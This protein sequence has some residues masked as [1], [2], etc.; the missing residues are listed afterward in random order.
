MTGEH[1][2]DGDEMNIHAPQSIQTATEL[3]LIA[4]A[5]LRFVSPAKSDIAIITKQDPVLG[6]YV[7]TQDTTNID[8]KD[9]MNILMITTTGINNHIPKHTIATGKSVF[10]EIIPQINMVRPNADGTNTMWIQN[11]ELINGPINKSQIQLIMRRSWIEYGSKETVN[12]VDDLQRLSLQFLMNDGV[13]IGAGDTRIPATARDAIYKIIETKRKEVVGSMTVYENDPYVMATEAFEIH[14]MKNLS[15]IQ[16]EIQDVVMYNIDKTCGMYLT[17]TSGSNGQP[18]NTGQI[19]ACIGQ[20][21]VEQQRIK[22]KF[23]NRTLPT[24]CQHD[25]S[26]FARGF[27]YNSFMSGMNAMEFFF[28]AM[29]GRE[30]LISTAIKTATTGYIQRK[31]VKFEEDFKVEYDG[32][33]R[34][35][36]DKLIQCA[37]GDNGINTENQ[38]SQKI[39]LMRANNQVIRDSYIYSEADIKELLRSK[40]SSKYSVKINE[41]LYGKLVSMRDSMRKIQRTISTKMITFREL[42]MVPIDLQQAIINILGR[43]NRKSGPIV[44]PYYV[45]R[46]V[47]EMYSGQFSRIM[48]YNNEG[49]IK[50]SDEQRIKLVLKFYLY[51]TLAPKR[52]THAYQLT[53]AEFD[54]IVEYF[55]TRMP[56]ARVEGGEMVG[57]MG[58]QSLGEPV[59]QLNLKTFHL[60]GTG[61]TVTSG[62]ARIQELLGVTKNM[63]SPTTEIILIDAY[64]N[65]KMTASKIA[66]HLKYTTLRD[67]IDHVDICY[68]PDPYHENSIMNQDK[69]TSIFGSNQGKSGCQTEIQGLPWVLRMPISKEKMI[70]RNIT[71]LEIKN[72]FCRNWTRRYEDS[73]GPNKEY[74]RVVDKIAQCALT[75]NFDNSPTPIV[76]IRFDANNYNFN[77]MIQFQEMVINKYRIKG[78]AGITE[79]KNVILEKYN[80]FEADGDVVVKEQY[81]IYTD[82]INLQD[83]AQIN[84][85]DLV[86]TMCNDVV[87]VYE[88]YGVEAARAAYIREF[89]MALEDSGATSN[90]QHIE[91]LTDAVTHMG[92]LIA[93]N[94][95]GANKLDTDPF[96]RASFEKTVEQMLGA[97]IFSES[98]HIRSVSS[99]IMVGSLINGGTGSFDV[100]L[101]HE[102]VQRTMPAKQMEAKVIA[103]KHTAIGDLIAKKKARNS[104]V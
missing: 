92:G 7:M 51:D 32:S 64:K 87:T 47:K 9:A 66:S 62:L 22:K 63:C 65:D 41:A 89:I 23:N 77:T 93:V 31:L 17:V 84:G 5:G 34:N 13:T 73:K 82:G 58:A 95:H 56:L 83:M 71:M 14:S 99:H 45:L 21:S 40:I 19:I 75:S 39:G 24:Y 68:D 18:I 81:V 70:E 20:L 85:I 26:P 80:T 44:D 55:N 37:Y 61:R 49:S 6:A 4:N 104:R 86:N 48:K 25:D 42:F 96:S 27:C 52:C 74:K 1:I 76:H 88:T 94:R 100:I 2:F 33:V 30:G 102:M 67:V 53:T 90:Y 38:V 46:A 43:P 16:S 78:I 54:E 79:S 10:S 60:A 72:S 35:A 8:W 11:G 3:R 50:H 69:A 36:N 28:Q 29:A 103:R 101:D 98:D 57:V 15:S 12:F 91:L 97:A 59:T